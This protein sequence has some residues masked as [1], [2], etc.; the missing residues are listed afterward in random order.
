MLAPIIIVPVGNKMNNEH[1]EQMNKTRKTDG[2][3]DC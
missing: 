1:Y 3:K 2:V